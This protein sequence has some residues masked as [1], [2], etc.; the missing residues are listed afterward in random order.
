MSQ[1]VVCQNAEGI[2]LAVDSKS[3]SFDS[4]GNMIDVQVDSLVQLGPHAAI[5]A[6]GAAESAEMCQKLR[7]FL[8]E[9]ELTDV[10]DI[11]TAA[12]P[13]LGSEYEKIM[14]TKCE[15]IPVDPIHHIYFILAGYTPKDFLRPFRMYMLWTK[16]KLPQLDGDE[17]GFAYTVPRR[18]GLE[19]KL[20]QL[21]KDNVPLSQVLQA[22]KESMEILG[23]QQEEVGPPYDFAS[24]TKEGFQKAD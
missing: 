20:N 12:L 5:L 4:S 19:Y 18:M 10:Q 17:I 21:A 15:T 9:E 6:G 13:F 24:I 14:R 16:K 23:Q 11:Y 8:A 22:I 7:T 2:V 1:L 3:V